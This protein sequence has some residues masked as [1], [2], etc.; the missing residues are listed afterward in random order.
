MGIAPYGNCGSIWTPNV[1]LSANGGKFTV[2][3][4]MAELNYGIPSSGTPVEVRLY[5]ADEIL[6]ETQSA[7]RSGIQ[8]KWRLM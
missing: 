2:K 5:N 6:Q 8:V 4:N 3:M 1:N 7:T